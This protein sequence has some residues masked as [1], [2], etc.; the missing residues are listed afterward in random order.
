VN[1]KKM[2]DLIGFRIT[3][4]FSDDLKIVVDLCRKIF[5][6][7]DL[8]YDAPKVEELS[9]LERIWFAVCLLKKMDSF[10]NSQMP[11]RITN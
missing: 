4:Y 6:V 3:S 11:A 8:E 7:I 5:E 9:H 2:Q 1:E 10:T